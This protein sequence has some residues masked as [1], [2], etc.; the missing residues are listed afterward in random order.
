MESNKLSQALEAVADESSFLRFVEL[1][2]ADRKL[3]DSAAPSS[4]G[5]Q[6]AWANQTITSFLGA[7]AA[8]ARDSGFGQHPG[9]K[10]NNS[11]QMFALFLWAGR[12][13]E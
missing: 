5:F 12:G 13:Y 11:W 6:D 7:A 3:A 1:L 4:D 9:P 8:W 2:G 10:P